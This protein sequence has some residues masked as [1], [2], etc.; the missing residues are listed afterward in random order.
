ML[1]TVGGSSCGD[2]IGRARASGR[3]RPGARLVGVLLSTLT[4]ALLAQ[5]G[6]ST[7][8]RVLKPEER[9]PID[10][11]LVEYPSGYTLE[12][13]I[14]NLTGATAITFDDKGSLIIAEGGEG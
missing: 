7:G 6:C 1:E 10:R 3:R 5:S 14:R 12:P 8:P 4:L 11:A 2:E 9:K 13:Y